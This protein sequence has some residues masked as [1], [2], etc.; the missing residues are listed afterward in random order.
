MKQY[1]GQFTV[2]A[3]TPLRLRWTPSHWA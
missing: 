2:T 1:A 3:V